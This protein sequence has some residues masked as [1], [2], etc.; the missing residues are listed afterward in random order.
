VKESSFIGNLAVIYT[1]LLFTVWTKTCK[2]LFVCVSLVMKLDLKLTNVYMNFKSPVL[3]GLT[4][5]V[6]FSGVM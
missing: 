1:H 4:Q 2:K 6:C 5:F 3:V